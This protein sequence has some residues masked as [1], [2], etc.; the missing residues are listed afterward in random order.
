MG[1]SGR[2]GG[3]RGADGSRGHETLKGRGL[4]WTGLQE[5]LLRV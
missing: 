1:E 3:A 2:E 5:L 4:G